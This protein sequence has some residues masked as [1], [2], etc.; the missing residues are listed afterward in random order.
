M[1][2]RGRDSGG[3]E[4]VDG[5]SVVSGGD[6]PEVL[7]A[8]DHAFD[9]VSVAVEHGRETVLPAPLGPGRDIGHRTVLFDL[10]ADGVAVVALVT[11][12]DAGGRH[13]LQ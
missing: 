4:E 6:A 12:E 11:M 2:G 7:E 9:G 5:V 8:A 1:A 13:L 3:R 10:P